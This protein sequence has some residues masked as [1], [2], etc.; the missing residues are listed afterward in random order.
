MD[1]VTSKGSIAKTRSVNNKMAHPRTRNRCKDSAFYRVL[2]TLTTLFSKQNR[3]S[4]GRSLIV[5]EQ[6]KIKLSL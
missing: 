5:K 1:L 2:L 3:L 6:K 4:L